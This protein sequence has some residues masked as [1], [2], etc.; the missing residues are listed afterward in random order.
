MKQLLCFTVLMPLSEAF[1]PTSSSCFGDHGHH[2]GPLVIFSRVVH[3]AALGVLQTGR[4]LTFSGRFPSPSHCEN[5]KPLWISGLPHWKTSSVVEMTVFPPFQILTL[6][7]REP[8]ADGGGSS[9]NSHRRAAGDK[10]PKSRYG[11]L[12]VLE[13]ESC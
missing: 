10:P 5:E 1:L 13:A 2:F 8:K 12:V 11:K 7:N 6:T 4:L 9:D 3:E